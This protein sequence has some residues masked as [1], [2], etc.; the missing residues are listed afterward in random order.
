MNETVRKAGH[1]WVP[2]SKTVKMLVGF[3]GGTSVNFVYKP[4]YMLVYNTSGIDIAT[5]QG[6]TIELY[7]HGP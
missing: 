3:K 4:V 6:T 2:L 7:K 5:E 1:A